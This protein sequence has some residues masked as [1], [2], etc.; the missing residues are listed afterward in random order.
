MDTI[1]LQARWYPSPA[2]ERSLPR[3]IKLL[4]TN[5]ADNMMAA[6]SPCQLEATSERKAPEE[7]MAFCPNCEAE[8][9]AEITVCPD[10]DV[11]L[12]PELT[13]ETE[14]HDTSDHTFVPFR[15]FS[16][17]AEADM[18]L[19]L[20]ERNEIR[21]YVKR[22]E[23]GIFGTSFHG[24]ALMVDEQDLARAQEIYEAFFNSDSTAPA[25]EDQTDT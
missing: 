14:V 8:Y 19:E 11:E 18:V 20:F 2:F 16:N 12:V 23:F 13:P 9:R 3:L 1:R 10:C 22:G 21:S 17:S 24:G 5:D 7:L 4:R 6:G 25:D 15:S